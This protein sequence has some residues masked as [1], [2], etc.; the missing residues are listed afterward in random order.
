MDIAAA[1]VEDEAK[2]KANAAKND[3]MNEKEGL[4]TKF[5]SL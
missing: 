3:Q 1:A 4:R 2:A 5:I